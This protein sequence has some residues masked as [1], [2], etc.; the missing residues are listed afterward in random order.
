MLTNVR[1]LQIETVKPSHNILKQLNLHPG[2]NDLIYRFK[3]S[4]TVSSDLSVKIFLYTE[5]SKLI[6]SDIDGTI[7]KSDVLGYLLPMIGINFHFYGI[8]KLYHALIQRGYQ[9]V[10]L[11]ARSIHEYDATRRYLCSVKDKELELPPGPVLMY[12]K[13][14]FGILKN[15]LITKQSDVC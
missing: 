9:F 6:I 4:S 8:V 13:S 1:E 15:D 2:E 11:T 12:P 10:Y 5:D 7:T 3:Y 14:F